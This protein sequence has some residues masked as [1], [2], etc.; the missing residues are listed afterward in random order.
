MQVRLKAIGA[1]GQIQPS[2]VSFPRETQVAAVQKYVQ[3]S[4]ELANSQQIW[5]Y[6]GNAFVPN[7]D[8]TL[9]TVASMTGTG[10]DDTVL[11]TYSIVEAFG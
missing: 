10:S 8:L 3:N 2:V 9:D 6:V 1:V 4:L 5:F 7:M 11:F